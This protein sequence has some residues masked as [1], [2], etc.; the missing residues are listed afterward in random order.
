MATTRNADPRSIDLSAFCRHG[1]SLEGQQPLAS[2]Q[3]L[4]A[5]LAA[6]PAPEEVAHWQAQGRLQPV[7][8]G[9]P[10]VWLH[11]QAQA[12][13]GLQ[14]QRCLQPMREALQVDRDFR[15]VGDEE[16]AARLD[17]ESEEDVL[18]MP[19]RIDLLEL[20]EDELILGLPI[21][22]RH[23]VCPNPLPMAVDEDDEEEPA[24]HPFAALAALRGTGPGGKH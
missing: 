13:V 20:L 9:Q 18:A 15:F 2:L 21:V 17:E 22:P 16:E 10:Q 4:S 11:L 24:P 6:D 12:E 14:C 1:A 8:G 19:A 23:E 7:S 5:G 3:R